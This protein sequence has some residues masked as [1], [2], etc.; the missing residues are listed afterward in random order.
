M[1]EIESHLLMTKYIMKMLARPKALGCA[2]I[3]LYAAWS[4]TACSGRKSD[5]LIGSLDSLQYTSLTTGVETLISD[6]GITKYKLVAATWYIFEE[7]QEYWYFPEGFY[8]EQFDT[9]FNI[10]ASI[11]ADTAYNFLDR[12]LWELRGNV[13]VL[14]REGQRFFGQS[15]FWD[16]NLQ[17]VYSMEHILIERSTGQLIESNDGFRSNQSMTRY[18]LFSSHGHIDVEDTPITPIGEGTELSNDSIANRQIPRRAPQ[19]PEFKFIPGFDPFS[20]DKTKP[21]GEKNHTE[22]AYTK[23]SRS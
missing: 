1:S 21:I 20:T 8:V 11:K 19:I 9:L 16:E 17:E 12:R 10:K 15:L 2:I 22:K 4:F 14:N 3:F 7:P 18:E 6:S 13:E 5:A 23:I